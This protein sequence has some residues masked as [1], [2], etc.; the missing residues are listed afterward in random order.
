MLSYNGKVNGGTTVNIR[1]AADG[2]SRKIGEFRTGTEVTII[3]YGDEWCEIEVGG[4]RGYVMTVF[5][6]KS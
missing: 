2:G 4:L 3:K 6:V 5:L 1:L